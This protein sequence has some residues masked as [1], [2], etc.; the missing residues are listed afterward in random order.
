MCQ[1]RPRFSTVPSSASVGMKRHRQLWLMPI[2]SAISIVAS[3]GLLVMTATASLARRPLPRSHPRRTPFVG[4]DVTADPA[5]PL[6]ALRTTRSRSY[7]SRA[8]RSSSE[9]AR[10]SAFVSPRKSDAVLSFYCQ[11]RDATFLR[12]CQR[13]RSVGYCHPSGMSGRTSASTAT[14]VA[15]TTR[16]AE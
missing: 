5:A 11:R 13:C 15:F 6:R 1:P 9:Q 3:P 12:Q 14:S 2:R 16:C 4:C 10:I 7:S 8:Q